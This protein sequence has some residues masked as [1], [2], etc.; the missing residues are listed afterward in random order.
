MRY[1][2]LSKTSSV[3]PAFADVFLE[4]CSGA[5]IAT[6]FYEQMLLEFSRSLRECYKPGDAEFQTLVA[7]AS[8]LGLIGVNQADLAR[9]LGITPM[10]LQRWVRGENL[11]NLLPRNAYLIEI[12]LFA[13]EMASRIARGSDGEQEK[14][15][16]SAKD[17]LPANVVRIQDL[18]E[19]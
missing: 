14:R 1:T 19:A 8:K 17:D 10:T 6:R 15:K 4:I 5:P 7:L 11:P 18:A 12:A 2:S 16:A 9:R 3:A 13:E